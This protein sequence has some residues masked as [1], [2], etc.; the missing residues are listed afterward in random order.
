MRTVK[1]IDCGDCHA[2]MAIWQNHTTTATPTPLGSIGKHKVVVTCLPDG[3][4][5]NN[6][7]AHVVTLLAGTFPSVRS[8]LS[9]DGFGRGEDPT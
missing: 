7:A 3:R 9:A 2:G 8:F 1:R 6:A 5:G 4:Y